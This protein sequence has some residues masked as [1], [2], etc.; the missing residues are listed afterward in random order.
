M[1]FM[2]I[3]KAN[4]ESEA[5]TMPSVELLDAMGKFNE[6]L[7]KA[8]VMV[9]GEGLHSS[10]KGARVRFGKGAPKVIDGPFSETKELV[11]GFWILQVKSLAECI[12]WVKRIPQDPKNPGQEGEVEIRQVAESEDFDQSSE[13][14]RKEPALRAEVERQ[15]AQ[16]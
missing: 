13:A 5:G 3:I 7:V 6:Q 16:R 2:V 4:A 11:A 15:N 10:A 9:G 8:G 12:E 1:R 14:I